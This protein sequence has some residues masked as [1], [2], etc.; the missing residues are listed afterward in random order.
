MLSIVAAKNDDRFFL[1]QLMETNI[2]LYKEIMPGAFERQAHLFREEGLPIKY[3]TSIIKDANQSIGFLGLKNL[4]H[5]ICYLVALYFLPEYQRKGFGIEIINFVTERLIKDNF[6]EIILLVHQK[7]KWAI[8]F[9]RKCGFKSISNS[10][11]EI[12]SYGD[13][14]LEFFYLP[15]TILM[16]KTF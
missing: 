14:V 12:K 3:T 6:N 15:S 2:P 8:D 13:R 9:Y 10:E 7:A 4:T 1:S 11:D 5:E 16:S